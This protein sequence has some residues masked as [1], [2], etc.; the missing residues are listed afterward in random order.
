M[1][2]NSPEQNR[3]K[4]YT[5][6]EDSLFKLVMYDAAEKEGCL[7]VEE[8][9]QLKKDPKN[10][11]SQTQIKEFSKLLDIHA[12]K[13]LSHTP[14][15]RFMK[16]LSRVAIV[17]L[18]VIIVFSTAMLTVQ[19]FRIRVLNFLISVESKYTS[20]QL[21]GVDS[22]PA[23]KNLVVNWTNAYVPTYI[24]DD[25]EVSSISSSESIKKLIFSNKKDENLFIMYTEC[26]P[27]NSIAVDTENASLVETVNI[28]D[29]IGKLVVKN[30]LITVVWEMD[31]RLFFVETIISP[32]EAVEIAK[33]VKFIK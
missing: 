3:Q 17:M 22:D 10:Q 2:K 16:M 31:G 6:Y 13:R 29:N 18:A 32:E 5:E 30:P 21:N 33:G 26:S 12:K 8:N 25:Y 19:A 11:P 27:S 23:G 24:P 14:K 1:S 9:E 28:N 7:F 15:P 20:F 4:L